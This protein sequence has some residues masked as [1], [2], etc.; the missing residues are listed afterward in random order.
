MPTRCA[1]T[2]VEAYLERLDRRWHGHLAR[3]VPAVAH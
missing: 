3:Y 2:L 1:C